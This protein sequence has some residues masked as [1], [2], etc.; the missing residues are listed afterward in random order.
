[1]VGSM[2]GAFLAFLVQYL[3]KPREM[4]IRLKE[5]TI[6]LR[7]KSYYD[8]INKLKA[9]TRYDF[10]P[11]LTNKDGGALYYP[12]VFETIESF[13]NHFDDLMNSWHEGE[14]TFEADV[15]EYFYRVEMYL[16]VVRRSIREAKEAVVAPLFGYWIASELEEHVE[17]CLD[18]FYDHLEDMAKKPLKK[19]KIRS[20]ANSRKSYEA[21]VTGSIM[22]AK[23][24]GY[25]ELLAVN[26]FNVENIRKTKSF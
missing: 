2:V 9:F 15:L 20:L 24:D 26:G 10:H 23:P 3:I 19:P 11:E 12:K 6:D 17:N 16:Y 13:D 8:L 18:L 5:K 4:S 21:I 25:L 1:M 14:H 7:F 22:H